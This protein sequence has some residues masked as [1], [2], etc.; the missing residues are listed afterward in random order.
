MGQ[1][2]TTYKYTFG[3]AASGSFKAIALSASVDGYAVG[4]Q[5]IADSNTD[6][7]TLSAGPNIALLSV[8]ESDII[9][10]SARSGGGGSGGDTTKGNVAY[11]QVF[12]L[13]G[14]WES[15][16]F[17]VND[18]SGEWESAYQ[19]VG[20]LSG[21]WES[22]YQNVGDLSGEWESTFQTVNAF[23][24]QWDQ[25]SGALSSQRVA[26]TITST[27]SFS[28]G[29]VLTMSE[30]GTYELASSN[31]SVSAAVIGIVQTADSAIFEIVHSGL[32]NWSSH[33]YTIGN[34]LYLSDA[35][36][37]IGTLT[38]TEPTTQTSISKPVGIVQDANNVLV[39]P[40]RGIEVRTVT[41]G[42]GGSGETNEY[43]FKTISVAG[44]N[45]G[46]NIGADV[47]AD[48]STDTVTLC[49]GPN[50]A[51]LTD[52]STDT[53]T[54]SALA[55]GGGGGGSGDITGV[56]LAGD[57]G[58][59]EDLT[60]NVNLTIAGG[61]A[62]TTSA[63]STT[64]TINHDDTSSQASVNNSSTTAVQDITLDTYGHVT[65]ITSADVEGGDV[66][67]VTLA[68]DS[69]SA[70]DT[71]GNVDLTIAGGSAI[72]TAG[73]STTITINH[74]DTSSQASVDNSG[75]TAVQDITLDTYGHVTGI[76][77]ADVGGG[78]GGVGGDGGSGLTTVTS[79]TTYTVGTGTG[80]HT[81]L[82]N[83]TSASANITVSLPAAAT[84]GAGRKYYFTI[85]SDGWNLNTVIIDPSGSEKIWLAGSECAT[86]VGSTGYAMLGLL[87]DG[88]RWHEITNSGTTWTQGI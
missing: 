76:T 18:L 23:S 77:S 58:T 61:S 15:T 5:V 83:S 41:D 26:Q 82:F 6:T 46:T 79:G 11:A 59:A 39:F 81:F 45:A 65:G 29:R 50:I 62:V 68:G 70:S 66:T 73:S 84:A 64:L 85:G 78:G 42:S 44:L 31:T 35:T 8:P 22:A 55:G 75:T 7:L 53:I 20:D 37:S 10:I 1:Q 47:V 2:G 30:A 33:G 86:V 48:T 88:A 71:S 17:D 54:I 12:D 40:L 3:K 28:A 19:N 25:S 16:Y 60:A 87:C 80:A 63:T 51:L 74:D 13:S 36:D 67:G 49:A 57:S 9:A 43:S 21:E 4:G 34:T 72:T 38:E 32:L 56:T 14:R 24:G 27:N 69:G 52:P